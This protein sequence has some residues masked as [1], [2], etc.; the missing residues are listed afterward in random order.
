M[1]SLKNIKKATRQIILFVAFLLINFDSV[2][3]DKQAQQPQQPQSVHPFAKGV[4]DFGGTNCVA[5][6]NQIATFLS[7]N[8]ASDY[9][10][11]TPKA[12]P[13]NSLLMASLIIPYGDIKD[14][15]HAITSINLA[16]NQANGCEGSYHS[17]FYSSKLCA[18]AFSDNYPSVKFQPINKTN[19][20]I[21]IINRGLWVVGMPAGD[22]G[23]VLIKEEL[24]Q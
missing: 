22:K 20:Q 11:Q 5:R 13:N 3:A 19:V 8:T 23:C 12:N 14:N 15:K 6:A 9:V 2:A 18:K 17:V 1:L 4:G 10:L 24:V 16:P 7:N 21:G